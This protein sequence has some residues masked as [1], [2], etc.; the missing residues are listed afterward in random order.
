MIIDPET[1]SED[2]DIPEKRCLEDGEYKIKELTS[3]DVRT[4]AIV[5]RGHNQRAVGVANGLPDKYNRD[6]DY[7]DWAYWAPA[8]EERWSQ[9]RGHR[10]LTD[11]E[12]IQT[13][14]PYVND[15]K[16]IDEI[17]GETTCKIKF[18]RRCV[19]EMHDN[20]S[21]ILR[22]LPGIVDDL[23][24]LHPL[25]AYVQGETDAL[26]GRK[27]YYRDQ[28]ATITNFIGDQGCVIIE[29]VDGVWTHWPYFDSFDE[30]ERK[31]SVKTDILSPHIWWWRD[32]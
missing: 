21:Y 32:E 17:R 12:I 5:G 8:G 3:D 18:N 16:G 9:F 2:K 29:R 7:V 23:K 10:T 15:W 1:V 20:L 22:K 31:E 19:Y 14:V 6:V 26:V 27:I 4:H 11:V 25:I 30:W 24:N 28:P 13:N